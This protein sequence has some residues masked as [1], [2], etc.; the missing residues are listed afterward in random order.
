MPKIGGIKKTSVGSSD[1]ISTNKK[2]GLGRKRAL[3]YGPPKV[4][5]TFLAATLSEHWPKTLPATKWVTLE[6]TLWLSFDAEATVGFLEQR[7]EVP[8]IDLNSLL[9]LDG[10]ADISGTLRQILTAVE[11]RVM[12][13]ETSLVV[14]DTI[15][16]LDKILSYLWGNLTPPRTKTGAVDGYGVWRMT[17]ASHTLFHNIVNAL[18]CDVVFLAHSKMAGEATQAK[19][20]AAALPGFSDVVVDSGY[21]DVGNIYR[22]DTSIIGHMHLDT[23]K[24]ERE[25]LLVPS[26][27]F[28]GGNRFQ[29]IL[30]GWTEPH[31]GKVFSKI[32]KELGL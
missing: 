24:N 30:D 19:S 21:Q 9:K 25:L 22:R 6:D 18:D 5:K 13:G 31:L 28:E 7:I 23:K 27:G 8:Q 26:K 20:K 14:V 12:A 4:G 15:S 17:L 3:I 16:K 32:E 11:E 10:S 1:L 29:R 2:A